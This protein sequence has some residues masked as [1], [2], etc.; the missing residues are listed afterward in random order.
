LKFGAAVF[1]LL[2]LALIAGCN[3]RPSASD[4]DAAVVEAAQILSPYSTQF[5]QRTDNVKGASFLRTSYHLKGISMA[6]AES[7]IEPELL[8]AGFKK[9]VFGYGSIVT[10]TF[11]AADRAGLVVLD[12]APESP[13]GGPAYVYFSISRRSDLMG[14]A[15]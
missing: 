14:G 2:V 12:T 13:V 7:K 15:K 4:R 9:R 10:C 3:G 1:G 11:T 6:D 8:H 5:D